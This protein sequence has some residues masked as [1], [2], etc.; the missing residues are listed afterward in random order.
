MVCTVYFI[1][2]TSIYST[3]VISTLSEKVFWLNEQYWTIVGGGIFIGIQLHIALLAWSK[4][5]FALQVKT[6]SPW[7]VRLGSCLC[8][9]CLHNVL[10]RPWPWRHAAIAVAAV[11][12]HPDR[13]IL[14]C[15]MPLAHPSEL[16][17]I[18]AQFLLVICFC[19]RYVLRSGRPSIN[20]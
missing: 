11:S 14:T 9:V 16:K 10:S 13:Q 19:L 1:L 3:Q 5:I 6:V 2:V 12:Q 18:L 15:Y 17:K 20:T 4:Y 7:A 8:A